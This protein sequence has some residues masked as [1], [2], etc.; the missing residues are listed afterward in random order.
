MYRSVRKLRSKKSR[1]RKEK[2]EKGIEKCRK[3][4]IAWVDER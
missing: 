1:E 4:K 3:R 2:K